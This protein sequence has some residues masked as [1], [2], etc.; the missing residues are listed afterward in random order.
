MTSGDDIEIT[1]QSPS[2]KSTNRI[3]VLSKRT[4]SVQGSYPR[5]FVMSSGIPIHDSSHTVAVGYATTW[6][7]LRYKTNYESIYGR[8]GVFRISSNMFYIC[9]HSYHNFCPSKRSTRHSFFFC[10]ND[11][12]SEM[13]LRSANPEKA[14]RGSSRSHYQLHFQVWFPDDEM[15]YSP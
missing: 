5:K 13:D 12:Y 3:F 2:T 14:I 1:D 6:N 10:I 8:D 9:Q 15:R 11:S 4:G 7:D